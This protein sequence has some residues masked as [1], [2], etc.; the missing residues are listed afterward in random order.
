MPLLLF[1]LKPASSFF[2]FRAKK[3]FKYPIWR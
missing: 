1:S 3:S 2:L